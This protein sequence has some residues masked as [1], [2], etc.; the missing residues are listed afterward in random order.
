[1]WLELHIRKESSRKNSEK[2]V[3]A[4]LGSILFVPNLAPKLDE[5]WNI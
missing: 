3:I 1:M 4:R 5:N 2:A